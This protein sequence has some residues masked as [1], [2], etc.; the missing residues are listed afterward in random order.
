M[1]YKVLEAQ[2]WLNKTYKAVLGFEQV[3]EDGI[4]G[5]QTM[6]AL[7]RALQNELGITVLSDTFGP[8]T[9]ASLEPIDKNTLNANIVRIFQCACFCK[10]YDAGD[11]DGDFGMQTERAV[12][13]VLNDMGLENDPRGV[14]PAKLMK[15]FL[16]MAA[17]VLVPAGSEGLRRAQQWINR[18]YGKRTNIAY[19]PCDGVF[20][21]DVQKMLYIA[22]QYELGLNDAQASGTFGPTTKKGL[23]S[24]P[25]TYV[26]QGPFVALFS[27]ALTCNRVL[28]SPDNYYAGVTERFNSDL[29]EG[30]KKFQEFSELTESGTVDFATW[31]QALIST[32]DPDRS[33]KACDCITTITDGR[34]Q[35][36]RAAGYTTVGRYLDERGTLNKKIQPGELAVIFRNGLRVFPISQYYGGNVDYF[37]YSQGFEDGVGAYAAAEGHRFDTGTVIYFAV[38]FDATQADIDEGVIPYFHGVTAALTV[39]G[40]KY[41]LGVYG[42]RNVCIDVSNRAGALWSFVSGMS[43]GFSGNLGYPLPKN[44]AFNQ[45]RPSPSEAGTGGSKSTRTS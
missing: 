21:R 40:D 39:R 5:W 30:I 13:Q 12:N 19:I 24:R 35:A 37:S 16:T 17:Y 44:W 32:G 11:I 33:A 43:T 25:L 6:H 45:F 28:L 2:K 3:V 31:C 1:D 36:L 34:A 15:S 9:M 22:I 10:G 8:T 27:A 42:S 18:T 20:S 7:T 23:Q 4:T 38:D 26:S 29:I 14:V 41:T